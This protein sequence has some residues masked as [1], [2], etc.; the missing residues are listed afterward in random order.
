MVIMLDWQEEQ[1]E[2]LGDQ[3]RQVFVSERESKD[4]CITRTG[5]CRCRPAPGYS[6]RFTK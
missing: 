6:P 4:C 5:C 3:A 2:E 1:L